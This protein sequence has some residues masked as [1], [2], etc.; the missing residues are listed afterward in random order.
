MKK[1]IIYDSVSVGDNMKRVFI[2]TMLC[3][4][5]FFAVGC[6]CSKQNNALPEKIVEETLSGQFF[7]NQML[8]TMEIQNFNIAVEDGESFISFDVSNTVDE[9]I[10]IEFIKILLYDDTDHLILESYGYVGGTLEALA[11]KH[12]TVD[13]DIDLSDVERVAYERM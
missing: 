8:D 4:C 9:P 2:F 10:S 6:G 3:C 5:S 12:I 13:V 7:E 11:T 1:S